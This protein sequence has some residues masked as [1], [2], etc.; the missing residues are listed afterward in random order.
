MAEVVCSVRQPTPHPSPCPRI[1]AR[2]QWALKYCRPRSGRFTGAGYR[3]PNVSGD[4][5]A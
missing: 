1:R 2:L 4:N 5:G 3:V